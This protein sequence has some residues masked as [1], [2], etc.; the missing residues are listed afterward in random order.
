MTAADRFDRS[1]EAAIADLAEPRYPDYFDH[2]LERSMRGAQRPAWTFPERWLPM[3]VLSLRPTLVPAV[4]WRTVG[5]VV[6]LALLAVIAV[7]IAVGTPRN[8][9]LP[10]GLA[11]NGAVIY[12]APD[13]DIYVRDQ[14]TAPHRRV[15]AGP[16][17]DVYPIFSRD[18]T[19]F[20]FFRLSDDPTPIETLMVADADGRNARALLGPVRIHSAS[21]SPGGGELAVITEDDAVRLLWVVPVDGRAA[22]PLSLPVVP[23][24]A[25]EWRPPDGG[26]LLFIGREPRGPQTYAIHA[27][28]PDGSAHRQ[29]SPSGSP[30]AYWAPL[31]MAPDGEQL[32]YTQGIVG[33]STHLL[34]ID[35]GEVRRFGTSLPPLENPGVGPQHQGSPLFSPD[36]SKLLFG[37]YWDEHDGTINHQLFLASADSDGADAFAVSPLVRSASGENPFGHVFAPDGTQILVVNWASEEVFVTPVGG[38]PTE[39]LPWDVND[40]PDWQ[41]AA[42]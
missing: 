1:I 38:G 34:D 6:I 12:A 23:M 35:D 3:R 29:V 2:V 16:E 9:P 24:S 40:P 41:R 18:G 30:N 19:K 36:G 11:A 31:A 42:P 22:R 8:L 28:R 5:L 15:I 33:V 13:G 37:R 7:A 14:W 26:E 21:W 20:V 10:Y 25:V 17:H 4:P 39:N 27:V 32:A